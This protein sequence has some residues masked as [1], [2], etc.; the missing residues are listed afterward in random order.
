MEILKNIPL[1]L[2]AKEI[3]SKL[4]M[5]RTGN[6]DMAQT[7]LE[8]AQPLLTPKA[9]YK[10]SYIDEKSEAAVVINGVRLQ[11][12]V[13]RKNLDN[14]GRVF[15][16]VVTIGDELEKRSDATDDF[17][18]KYYLDSIGNI[19]LT[20]AIRHLEA[21]LKTKFALEKM[22]FMAPGSLEDWPLTEQTHLFSIL[23]DVE[24]AIGVRLSEYLL[25]FPRKSESGIYFPAETAFYSC[26]LCPRKRCEERKARYNAKLA[27]EYR[28]NEIKVGTS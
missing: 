5:R 4:R 28:I 14:V 7:L 24:E 16:Y 10:V 6:V 21:H 22:A 11:S 12:R 2:K 27:Q 13:L 25:M 9:L 1:N 18:E 3:A 19:A 17:L 20:K 15:P 8:I 26:Q 23:G